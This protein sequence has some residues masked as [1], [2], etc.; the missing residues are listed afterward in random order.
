L[1]G[2]LGKDLDL[3]LWMEAQAKKWTDAVG[4]LAYVEE[5]HPQAAYVGLQKLLQ[6]EWQF[7]QIYVEFSGIELALHIQFLP[8]ISE[9]R[10]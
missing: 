1:G 5:N 2:F 7:L 10:A 4:V 6:Q 8:A 3:T 9:K